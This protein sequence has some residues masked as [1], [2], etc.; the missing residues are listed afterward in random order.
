M[1]TNVKLIHI[2]KVK[3]LQSTNLAWLGFW[4]VW[5]LEAGAEGNFKYWRLDFQHVQ[6][7]WASFKQH[8]TVSQQWRHTQNIVNCLGIS[9]LVLQTD[10]PYQCGMT[11]VAA[12]HHPNSD[13]LTQVCPEFH[14]LCYLELFMLPVLPG[15]EVNTHCSNWDNQNQLCDWKCLSNLYCTLWGLFSAGRW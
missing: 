7:N 9:C 8:I 15:P 14:R 3:M 6:K 2:E 10:V 1:V 12:L 13:I 11:A 4:I 5:S